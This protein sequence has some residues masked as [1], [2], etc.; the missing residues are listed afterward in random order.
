MVMD[1]HWMSLP[2]A[3]DEFKMSLSAFLDDMLSTDS[4]G[5][6]ICC[7]CKKCRRRFWHYRE[8]IYDHLIVDGVFKHFKQWFLQRQQSSS[9][10]RTH[11]SGEQQ[12]HDNIA[13]LLDDTFRNVVGEFNEHEGVQMGYIRKLKNSMSW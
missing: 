1:E 7:P 12:S 2:K 13:G 3:S 5:N 8:D 9:T 6:Q 10:S 4:V 11:E